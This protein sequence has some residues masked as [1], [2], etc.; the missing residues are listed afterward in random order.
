[1]FAILLAEAGAGNNRYWQSEN[2][3]R[4]LLVTCLRN[5]GAVL[6]DWVAYHRGLGVT[7]VL[8]YTN[9][10]DDGTDAIADRLQALGFATHIPN[11]RKG[12]K[13]IQWQAL[14]RASKHDA[15]KAADWVTAADVDEYL[16]IH[17]GEGRLADLFAARP[18]AEGFAVPWRLFG[19]DGTQSE[20]TDQPV[21]ERFVHAAPDVLMWPFRARCY[22]AIWRNTGAFRK[23]GVHRPQ[24]V[25]RDN[26]DPSKWVD[27]A[28]RTVPQDIT[29]GMLPAILHARPQYALAQWN[30]YALGSAEDFILKAW[31]GKPNHESEAIGLEYWIA[32]N[33][34][35]Q[36]DRS[37][38]TRWSL[39][40]AVRDQMASD[41]P[42]AALHRN[43]IAWRKEKIAALLEEEHWHRLHAAVRTAPPARVLPLEEQLALLERHSRAVRRG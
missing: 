31:R 27:G 17:A 37:V 13:P 32:N 20:T 26:Y 3:M 7:D 25:N 29:R 33:F 5:E 10:C 8:L 28:G 9:D 21:P 14:G 18:D 19:N 40:Q 41:A 39:G 2:D 6:L 16:V 22:K 4:V 42:L 24:G 15:F 30:H 34:C 38:L 12:D 35:D 11:P 23:I 36:V 43:A 1:M